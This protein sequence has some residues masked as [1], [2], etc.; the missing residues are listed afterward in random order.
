MLDPPPP[1]VLEAT[2]MH[3]RRETEA[4]MVLI[5]MMIERVCC[6]RYHTHVDV[7]RSQ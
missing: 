6:P 7:G 4:N 2:D 3:R 5:F 1:D